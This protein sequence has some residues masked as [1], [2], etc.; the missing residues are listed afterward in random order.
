MSRGDI[1]GQAVPL[2]CDWYREHRRLLPWRVDPMPYHIWISEI[3]L[4]QTRIE[5]VIPYYHRFLSALPDVRSLSEVDDDVL[6]KLWQG[7]GYYSRARNLKK[8]AI[9]LMD[10]YGGEFPQDAKTLR[11]LPGIGAYTAGAIASIAFHK[12]EPAVDG[13]V[14]RVVMRL[15][16]DDRDIM[17]DKTRKAVTEDLRSVYPSGEDAALLTE[18]IME[19]G[20][21]VC[22]PNGVPL[23][24]SC[25]LRGICLAAGEGDPERY[26]TRTVKTKRRI[27]DRTVLL[28]VHDGRYALRKRSEKGL[29]AGMWELP[30]F[31]GFCT[32][33]ELRQK[34]EALGLP[35]VAI[36]PCGNSTHVFSHVEWHMQGY[37]VT[38]DESVDGYEWVDKTALQEKYAL[39]TAFRFYY[40]QI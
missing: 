10:N 18:G 19:L 6:M 33:A 4:Q 35:S 16:A 31:D 25:P 20:E 37:R 15:L 9:L 24:G 27:E 28:L 13:N 40:K 23:C 22:I 1:L 30:S 26:P 36:T 17:V 21:T 14:L 5:A 38:L 8:A 2:L 12:P 11:S 39:P 7:L 34:L 29:L 3:M 32:M